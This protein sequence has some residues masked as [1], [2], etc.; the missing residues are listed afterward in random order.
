MARAKVAYVWPSV[1]T[2]RNECANGKVDPRI[3]IIIAVGIWGSSGSDGGDD[4]DGMISA[5]APHIH[6]ETYIV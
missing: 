6:I 5:V 2:G 3:M 4:N 1:E